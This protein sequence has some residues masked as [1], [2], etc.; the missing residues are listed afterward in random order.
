MLQEVRLVRCKKCKGGGVTLTNNPTTNDHLHTVVRHTPWHLTALAVVSYMAA[1]L[2]FL[3]GLIIA[4]TAS[5]ST[6]SHQ[7]HHHSHTPPPGSDSVDSQPQWWYWMLGLSMYTASLW[8]IDCSLCW[9]RM[10][11][12]VRNAMWLG[13]VTNLASASAGIAG[14]VCQA[15]WQLSV[16]DVM[17]CAS[18]VY[19][20]DGVCAFMLFYRIMDHRHK[21][22]LS[23]EYLGQVPGWPAA[24]PEWRMW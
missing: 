9:T 17:T 7:H 6:S 2:V 19:L 16:T 1:L 13:A 20:I 5:T 15:T 3:S 12:F 23:K 4:F 11:V 14:L 21:V 18:T 22:R 8:L 10:D 24:Q